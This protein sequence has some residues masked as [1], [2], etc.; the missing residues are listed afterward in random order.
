MKR[1]QDAVDVIIEQWQQE[2]PRLGAERLALL[3]RLKRCNQLLQP[4]IN[5]VFEQFGLAAWGFDVL[6][7]LRR[8]G[9]PYCLSPT[10][11][12]SE[13][14][15]TSGTM[16]TRLGKLEERGWISRHANPDDAR[17]MLVKLTAK[18]RTL[19]DKVLAAHVTN[20]DE[21]LSPLPAGKQKQIN[22]ALKQLLDLLEDGPE[23]T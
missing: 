22:E 20:V 11:L 18:G 13:L 9:S 2:M 10:E 7:A 6:A 1:K 17:S 16:T 12:F 3:E 21:L 15:V 4:Q 23:E 5:P 8:S 19:I 14:L